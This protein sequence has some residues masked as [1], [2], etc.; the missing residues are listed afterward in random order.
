VANQLAV[1]L[2]DMLAQIN[3]DVTIEP[4]DPA[5]QWE[6]WTA[7]DYD[8]VMGNGTSDNLDPNANM[9]FCCVS[10]GGAKSSY[11]GWVDPEVD[12]I[13]RATQAEMDFDARGE[14][15]DEFQRLVMERGPFI[16][17]VHQVN[18]YGAQATV[19]NF[20]LDPTG[21]WHLEYVWKE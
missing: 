5:T 20:F 8:M 6:R 4:I 21:H 3:I 18:R 10:D 17:L 19:H 1:M 14:L 11:T 7:L 13:F 9:L 12:E 16:E 15:Y 2:K